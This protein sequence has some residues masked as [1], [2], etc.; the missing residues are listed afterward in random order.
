MLPMQ[1]SPPVSHFLRV[2][3][4]MSHTAI[5]HRD[6]LGMVL[7]GAFRGGKRRELDELAFLGKFCTRAFGIMRRIGPRG[8]GYDRLAAELRSNTEK[9][10]QLF[11]SLTGSLPRETQTLLASRY[12]AMTT[13]GFEN[14]MTLLS[15]L[16][17]VK[18]WQIDNREQSPW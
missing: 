8:E 7:E 16:S 4:Q 15:D 6:D 11:T 12:L 14:L 9:A 2:L 5:R 1:L 10:K 18:N 3:D 13:E 17:W